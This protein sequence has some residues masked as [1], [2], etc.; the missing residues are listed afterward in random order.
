[1][2]VT[3]DMHNEE[4]PVLHFNNDINDAMITVFHLKNDIN[5]PIDENK[6][7]LL[8]NDINVQTMSKKIENIKDNEMN[9]LQLVLRSREI[10]ESLPDENL[11]CLPRENNQESNFKRTGKREKLRSVE[12]V[13]EVPQFNIQ[14]MSKKIENIKDNDMNVIQ[15]VLRSREIEESL[16]DENLNRENNQESLHRENN[17]ESL[18]DENMVLRPWEIEESLQD[19]NLNRENNQESNFK[20]T[21]KREKRKWIE[22]PR[23]E[24]Y[25]IS[26]PRFTRKAQI[27]TLWI[28]IFLT[29]LLSLHYIPCL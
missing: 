7:I 22:V 6:A 26:L 21:G 16:Q 4:M 13:I 3:S 11:V 24:R 29:I 23:P 14:K 25:Q 18:P 15:L 17:Q 1:M 28:C 2:K 9:V 8:K 10:E 5:V 19:E 12:N 27:L 20:R